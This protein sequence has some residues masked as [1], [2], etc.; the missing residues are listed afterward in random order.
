MWCVRIFLLQSA[1]NTVKDLVYC[2]WFHLVSTIWSDLK[3]HSDLPEK[4][5]AD[6]IWLCK[7]VSATER[8]MYDAS[9]N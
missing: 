1:N 6:E 9:Q 2:L 3:F 7:K 5:D 8:R 4:V